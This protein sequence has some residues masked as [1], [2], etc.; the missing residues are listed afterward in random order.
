MKINKNTPATR[1]SQWH[2]DCFPSV[3]THVLLPS[4]RPFRLKLDQTLH[5]VR[6]NHPIQ[7]RRNPIVDWGP[8]ALLAASPI[9][10]FFFLLLGS[11]YTCLCTYALLRLKMVVG[12]PPTR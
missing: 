8:V 1:P 5:H 12:G 9:V 10:N 3:L 2:I 11:I 6:N 7:F 4:E